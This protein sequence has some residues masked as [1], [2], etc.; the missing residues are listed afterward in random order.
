MSDNHSKEDNHSE[1]D[2]LLEFPCDFGIKAIGLDENDFDILVIEII[3]KHVEVLSDDAVETRQSSNKKY[4]SVTVTITAIS[5]VQLDA[6]YIEL[7]GHE[8]VTMAL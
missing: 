2:T 3:K 1:Q 7:S 6:I 8:R 5:K 4:L